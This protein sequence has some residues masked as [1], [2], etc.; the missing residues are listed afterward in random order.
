MDDVTPLLHW[1]Q[2][3]DSHTR[4]TIR[5]DVAEDVRRT[6]DLLTSAVVAQGDEIIK[7]KAALNAL[8]REAGGQA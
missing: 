2:R 1:R 5:E 8:A 4:E 6:V 7:L 3:R